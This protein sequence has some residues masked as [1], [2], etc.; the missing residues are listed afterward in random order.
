MFGTEAVHRH[1]VRRR[2]AFVE[3]RERSLADD[4]HRVAVREERVR[5][6]IARVV[7]IAEAL[8]R[9]IEAHQ[10]HAG[11][12]PCRQPRGSG[13]TRVESSHL[14]RHTT[15]SCDSDAGAASATRSGGASGTENVERLAVHGDADQRKPGMLP[16]RDEAS[17]AVDDHPLA[18]PHALGD[19]SGHGDVGGL[20]RDAARNP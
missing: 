11:G 13:V 16:L 17:G 6:R 8:D 10:P 14:L 20:E 7:R 4:Q 18:V 5:T 2:E 3:L 1:R 19:E 12:E 15:T 9:A